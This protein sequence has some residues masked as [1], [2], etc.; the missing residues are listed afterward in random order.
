VTHEEILRRLDDIEREITPWTP[1]PYAHVRHDTQAVMTGRALHTF[2]ELR[3]ELIR[4]L[5]EYA[6]DAR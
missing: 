1:G 2:T 6:T 3:L 4:F 5:R